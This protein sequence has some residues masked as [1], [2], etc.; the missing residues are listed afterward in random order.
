MAGEPGYLTKL[1]LSFLHNNN[2]SFQND[3]KRLYSLDTTY[4]RRGIANI[5]NKMLL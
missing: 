2:F 4:K 5:S 1:P 3:L